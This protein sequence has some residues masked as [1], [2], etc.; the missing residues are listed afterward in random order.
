AEIEQ[1]MRFYGEHEQFLLLRSSQLVRPRACADR[2]KGF[3]AA[4]GASETRSA[5][6][7]APY[8]S[9]TLSRVT[10]TD[11][12]HRRRGK[13]HPGAG[14]A[15]ILAPG[16]YRSAPRRTRGTPIDRPAA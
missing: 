5:L 14:F 16:A 4:P 9:T 12:R 8:P 11:H 1:W 3:V 15:V 10:F 7:S 2:S 13:D 6:Q